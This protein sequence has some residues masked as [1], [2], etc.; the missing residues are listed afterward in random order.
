MLVMV[1]ASCSKDDGGGTIPSVEAPEK[2]VLVSPVN[3]KA[4]EEVNSNGQITFSW[5]ESSNTTKYDLV[6]T[7]LN[8]NGETSYKD[9]TS[10]SKSVSLEKGIP[11]SWVIISKNSGS[12]TTISDNWLF[13][14]AGDGISNYAPFPATAVAP[15]PGA[16]V[17]PTDGKVT[18]QWDSSDVDQDSLTYTLYADTQDGLQDTVIIGGAAEKSK[19]MDVELDKVY[20]WRVKTSDGNNTSTSIVYTFRTSN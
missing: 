16:T 6:I 8:T 1:V 15:I 9:L 10:T 2:T 4:C 18:I 12:K 5:N 20:Y 7:N 14:L 19:I 13:Y 17:T 11:Y 3:N